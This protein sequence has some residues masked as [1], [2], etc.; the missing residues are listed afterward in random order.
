MILTVA[1]A[2]SAAIA[3]EVGNSGKRT[4]DMV[5]VDGWVDQQAFGRLTIDAFL[6]GVDLGFHI[7]NDPLV[8]EITLEGDHG[9]DA[10]GTACGS[11]VAMRGED[12]P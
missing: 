11:T 1:I 7:L 12:T 3:S 5:D 10:C 4:V 6:N 8:V 2:S 9:Q